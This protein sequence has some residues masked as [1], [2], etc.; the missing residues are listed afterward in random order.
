M[1]EDFHL[2]EVVQLLKKAPGIQVIDDPSR[3]EYPLATETAGKLD[4]FVGRI[5]RDLDHPRAINMWI[6][7]D[8]LLKGAAW[9]AVQIAEEMINS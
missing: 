9:N 5:R 7:S 8:N 6:V 2:E 4:V 1:K 3:Q